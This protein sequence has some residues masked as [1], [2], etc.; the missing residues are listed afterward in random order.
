MDIAVGAAGVVFALL[1]FVA[2]IGTELLRRRTDHGAADEPT[3]EKRVAAAAQA[4][5]ETVQLLDD[6]ERDIETRARRRADLEAQIAEDEQLAKLS[7]EQAEAVREL[8]SEEVGDQLSKSGRRTFWQGVVVNFVFFL[9][10]AGVAFVFW[11][12]S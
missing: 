2:S 10:G 8:L 9:L 12:W 11:A 3:V 5:R 6:L 4:L 7:H 1:G